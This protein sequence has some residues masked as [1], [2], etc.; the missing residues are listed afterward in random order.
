MPKEYYYH[1]GNCIVD[2]YNGINDIIH[3]KGLIDEHVRHIVIGAPL[4][5]IK[6]KKDKLPPFP[7]HKTGKTYDIL[8]NKFRFKASILMPYQ[9]NEEEIKA[10]EYFYNRALENNPECK[11]YLIQWY[12]R[13]LENDWERIWHGVGRDS[14]E[15]FKYIYDETKK[16]FPNNDCYIAPLGECVYQIK[17]LIENKGVKELKEFNDLFFYA[18][19]TNEKMGGRRH[20]YK[21]GMYMF[22]CLM[23]AAIYQKKPHDSIT[24]GLEF[25]KYKGVGGYSVSEEFAQIAWDLVW[26]V[27]CSEPYTGIEP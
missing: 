10:I 22:C 1:I 2:Q 12:P 4:W 27:L 18:D 16:L 19:Q 9:K 23:Y 24:S 21:T 3:S 20:F 15:S 7:F 6:E 14:K 5:Y 17:K 11:L 25:H 26:D 8:F 13:S